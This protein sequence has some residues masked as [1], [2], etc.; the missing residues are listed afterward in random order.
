VSRVETLDSVDSALSDNSQPGES[1]ESQFHLGEVFSEQIQ[2]SV[3]L[4]IHHH[5][6]D[7]FRICQVLRT[8]MYSALESKRPEKR[9]SASHRRNEHKVNL[10][11]AAAFHI[12][13]PFIVGQWLRSSSASPIAWSS[14]RSQRVGLSVQVFASAE[15]VAICWRLVR[16]KSEIRHWRIIVNIATSVNRFLIIECTLTSSNVRLSS[17]ISRWMRS[18]GILASG[19]WLSS[20]RTA[21][22][23]VNAYY[24]W[25]R[26]LQE[27]SHFDKSMSVGSVI[28]NGR[29]K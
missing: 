11:L 2:E 3:F 22:L 29:T 10:V 24:L 9:K 25:H 27:K 19:A 5:S 26:H 23:F 17:R 20:A 18:G 8:A 15:N 13:F 12:T 28:D 7:G 6:S 1:T 16:L 4:P 21:K 14:P